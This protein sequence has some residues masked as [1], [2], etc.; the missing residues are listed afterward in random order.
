MLPRN[1]PLR[2]SPMP[3]GKTRIRYRSKKTERKYVERRALVAELFLY[4]T[5]CVVPD[6]AE[7][8]TDPHEPLTRARGGDICDRDNVLLLC[9]SHHRWAHDHPA[10]A[11][12][13]GLLVHSWDGAR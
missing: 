10:E 1:V 6:C 2:R 4:P 12:A 3:A 8:A 7:R 13:L 5:V 9:R 11:E